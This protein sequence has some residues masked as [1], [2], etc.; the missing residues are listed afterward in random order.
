MVEAPPY[1]WDSPGGKTQRGR[2]G[3][4]GI[5]ENDCLITPDVRGELRLLNQKI[6]LRFSFPEVYKIWEDSLWL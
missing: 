2:L 3:E 1:P 5:K 4:M 6:N